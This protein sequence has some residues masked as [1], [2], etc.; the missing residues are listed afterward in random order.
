MT[1]DKHTILDGRIFP[2]LT[3]F[4]VPILFSLILQAL[5]GA[6]DLWMVS[7]F[8]ANA[9][10]SAVSTG[11]QTMMITGGLVTGLSMGITVLLGQSVGQG[12]D[13][14]SANIIGTGAWIFLGIGAIITAVLLGTAKPLAELLNAPA[15]AF[16]QT[17]AYILICGAGTVFVVG[18]NVLNGIFC[19]L[20]DSKTPLLF[21]AV[22]CVVNIL[23]DYVLIDLLQLGAVGAAI[24]TIAAQAVSVI[25]S[26]LVIRKKLPFPI[27]KENLRYDRKLAGA[28]LRLGAPVALLRMCTEIS[29]LVIL[30]FVN[31]FGETASSGVG[32]AEKLVMF[33]LLIPTAYRSSISAFVAQNMGANQPERAK[34]GLWTGMV[35]AASIGGVMAYLSFFHGDALSLLFTRDLQVIAASSTFLKATAM[36]CFVLSISYCFDGYFNGIGKTTLVMVRGV[37]AALLVRIPYAYYASTRPDSSLFQIGLATAFAAIFMLVFCC[38]EYLVRKRKM[39]GS[40]ARVRPASTQKANSG[41]G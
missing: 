23:G 25:F 15:A 22:A 20:G 21:V 28:I 1:A 13:R 18:F 12:N 10:V 38:V 2:A 32:I 24:A 35:S 26:L 33:I 14:R 36:E 17:V 16:D 9:D 6:V 8:A 3:R 31:V 30:G 27:A 19:G 34:Q 37:A 40:A 5:Y 4:S 11:S 39:A 29:Y 41:T 7:H